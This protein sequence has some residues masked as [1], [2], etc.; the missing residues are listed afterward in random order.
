MHM[1][2][3]IKDNTRLNIWKNKTN[4]STF[5]QCFVPNFVK[6]FQSSEAGK[7]VA[8]GW[9]NFKTLNRKKQ[10]F[11]SVPPITG[12]KWQYKKWD[13]IQATWA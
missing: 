1:E 9:A 5:V 11:P 4:V 6:L 13:E 12:K 8:L 10:A 2:W 7:A 3:K